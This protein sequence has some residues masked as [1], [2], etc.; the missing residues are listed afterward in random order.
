[1]DYARFCQMMLGGGKLG[2][3]RILSRKSVELMSHDQLGKIDRDR[4]YGLG[5]G[6]AGAKAPLDELGTVGSFNWGGFYYTSFEIDPNEDMV[7]V[8]MA[9]LHPTGG[10]GLN[11]EVKVLAYQAIDD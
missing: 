3:V 2:D 4:G 8:S 9:Q 6:V 11:A 5:F 7:I 10:L 1:M